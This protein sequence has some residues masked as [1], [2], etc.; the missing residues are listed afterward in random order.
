M[1]LRHARLASRLAAPLAEAL[2]RVLPPAARVL[3]LGC[4]TG[5]LAVEVS[6]RLPGVTWRPSDPDPASRASAA[7]WAARAGAANVLPPLALDLFAPAW[8]L[9]PCDAVVAVNVLHAA[10]EGAAEAL[11]AGAAAALPR[12]GWL[13][14]V[15]LARA[16]LDAPLAALRGGAYGHGFAL[17]HDAL[18]AAGCRLLLLQRA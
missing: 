7:G 15:G 16:P 6:R 5:E 10:G 13:V 9:Q 8:R 3:E 17:R 18:L 11:L 12:G 14:A 4:G 2:A 1:I